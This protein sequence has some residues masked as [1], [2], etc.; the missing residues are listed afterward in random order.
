M[1][2]WTHRL[3]DVGEVRLHYV[4]AGAGEPVVL[5][6]GWPQTWF[7]WRGVIPALTQHYRVIA[8]DLRGLGES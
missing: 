3:A 4:E 5:L 8:V 7:M 1:N 6:H 2:D